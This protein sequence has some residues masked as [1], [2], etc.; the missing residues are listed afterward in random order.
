MRWWSGYGPTCVLNAVGIVKQL[1][2]AKAAIP[3]I[4]V[5]SLWPHVLADA[6]ASTGRAW[7]T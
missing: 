4:S 7:C 6:C 2:D 1:A 3:S 5:N